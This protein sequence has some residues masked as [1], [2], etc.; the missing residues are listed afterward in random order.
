MGCADPGPG[1]AG[2]FGSEW[3]IYSIPAMNKMYNDCMQPL[4]LHCRSIMAT[5]V[6]KG[7]PSFQCLSAS[8]EIVPTGVFNP[9]EVKVWKEGVE[10][11]CGRKAC[12]G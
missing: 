5:G 7:V 12:S 2:S 8:I 3:F 10:G 9:V 6:D 11:R 1:V 4:L